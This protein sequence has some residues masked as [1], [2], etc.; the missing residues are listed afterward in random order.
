[1]NVS[2]EVACELAFAIIGEC[3]E[4]LA[5][6]DIR[7]PSSDREGLEE[8][9]CIYGTT[10]YLLEDAITEILLSGSNRHGEREQ[11]R[12]MAFWIMEEFKELLDYHSLKVPSV[13]PARATSKLALCMP[14]WNRLRDRIV[15]L[16][17][18]QAATGSR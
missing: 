5:E 10:Y 17:W 4:L 7:I 3:E 12:D 6:H 14:E 18:R 1:M 9:A 8:E 16:L 2:A 11:G 15:R 13:D